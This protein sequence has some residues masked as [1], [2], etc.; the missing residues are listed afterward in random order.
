MDRYS[1]PP[2]MYLNPAVSLGLMEVAEIAL[3][4]REEL[5]AAARPVRSNPSRTTD[6]HKVEEDEK[7]KVRSQVSQLRPRL[8]PDKL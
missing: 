3:A 5:T 1:R 8:S 4:T 7:A 6:D 2:G